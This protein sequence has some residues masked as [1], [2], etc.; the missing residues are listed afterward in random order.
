M[1]SSVARGAGLPV[2]V[3]I[4]TVFSCGN[5]PS[6][7]PSQLGGDGGSSGSGG[8]NAS[9]SGTG[10]GG[11]SSS[12]STS[13]GQSEGG[14]PYDAGNPFGDAGPIV[15][16]Q[17]VSANIVVDQFG[18]R[19]ADEK[20]AV[21]RNPKKGFDSAMAFTPGPTYALVDAHSSAK[22]LEAAPAAWNGGATDT[23]SGDQAWVFDF[24]SVT[25]QG[26][27]F[28]LDEKNAV[29]SPVFTVWDGVYRDVLV[30]STRMYYYQRS[31]I[32][33]DAKYAGAAWADTMAHPQDAKCGLYSD[34]SGPQ[35]LHGGWF[36]AGDENTYTNWA[37]SDVIQL[38]HAYV[39]NPGAFTDD[40]NI[41]ESGNGVPDILD[42]VKWELDWMV[43]MQ[44]PNGSALSIKGHQGASPPSAD[45]APCKYGSASTSA[46]FSTAAAFAYASTI[47]KSATGV[48]AAYPGY[49]AGLAAKAQSA[50][51]WAVANPNVTFYNNTPNIQPITLGGG[52]QEVDAAGL[53]LKK[54]QAAVYLFELTGTATYQ[55]FVDA[56]YTNLQSAFDSS[57]LDP[58]D[59]SLEYA[60]TSTA[61]ASVTQAILAN[62]KTQTENQFFTPESSQQ[63]PYGSALPGYW[64]GS[65]ATK[66]SQGDVFEAFAFHNLD[67]TKTADALRYAER[68]IHYVHGVN[69]LQLVYLSAMADH[70]ASKFV[71]RFFHTWFAHGS[72]WDQAGVSKYGPPPGYLVGGPN[73]SYSWDGCCPSGCNSAMNNAA[74]GAALPL[75]PPARV[76]RTRS[77]IWTSTITGPSDSWSKSPSLT[78]GIR[79]PGSGYCPSS[80]TDHPANFSRTRAWNLGSPRR[81]RRGRKAASTR[82]SRSISSKGRAPTSLAARTYGGMIS[83]RPCSNALK[84]SDA[85][86]Y[87]ADTSMKAG[88]TPRM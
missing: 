77:R 24:S 50:W 22:L 83:V 8:G 69:P 67:S 58:L 49:A 39:E 30:Q 31:G 59:A 87:E 45:T 10:S 86:R 78:W 84:S 54:I 33:H 25:T 71:T 28:V 43:R 35:D 4:A 74:C 12:G 32:A 73:P 63:D 46:S 1:R 18:Y 56:N 34:G 3:F 21:I 81:S 65:N 48:A 6:S 38:M 27:Y 2:A 72:V 37:A 42:E 44:Q 79:P 15:A 55:T 57:H 16:T 62:Y 64:W 53:L 76:S 20:L 82:S 40:Y 66:S 60:G 70:G 14:T 23:S 26:Q 13:G 5:N 61:T 11:G 47:F 85:F 17:P 68:Y 88:R 36:D 7:A 51:T 80:C 9:N 52:E 75:S 41:P 29:R 19:T